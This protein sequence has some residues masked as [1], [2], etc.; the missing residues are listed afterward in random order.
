MAS[1]DTEE[2][3]SGAQLRQA[4]GRFQP[5]L[6]N[7]LD[8][9]NPARYI[10]ADGSSWASEDQAGPLARSPEGQQIA[11]WEGI[12]FRFESS[13]AYM[14][15]EQTRVQLS[16]KVSYFVPP[17]WATFFDAAGA[18]VP[19]PGP[20]PD[21]FAAD[22]RGG[23]ILAEDA[24]TYGGAPGR[25]FVSVR[26]LSIDDATDLRAERRRAEQKA[27]AAEK[28]KAAAAQRTRQQA[29][30]QAYDRALGNAS[31]D[32][33]TPILVILTPGQQWHGE[34]G[35]KMVVGPRRKAWEASEGPIPWGP[36]EVIGPQ[37]I[38]QD[39]QLAQLGVILVF[40]ANGWR[41][42]YWNEA[43]PYRS[44]GTKIAADQAASEQV[45]M[46]IA[47]NR[48]QIT[49]TQTYTNRAA[50]GTPGGVIRGGAGLTRRV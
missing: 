39:P 10:F 12:P 8:R 14:L 7:V 17:P 48:A 26:L 40:G 1:L 33:Q 47:R 34:T 23:W 16:G 43:A 41:R 36:G 46:N 37:G 18:P 50:P 3:Y 25:A 6:Q 38:Y 35:P 42:P 45:G 44:Q 31:L 30:Q 29:Y 27:A 24:A 13:N 19:R 2:K 5:G 49:A 15:G 20:R 4:G 22:D 32:D 11:Q 21:S 28:N 9:Y